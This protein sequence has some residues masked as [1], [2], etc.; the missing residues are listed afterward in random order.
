MIQLFLLMFACIMIVAWI[1]RPGSRKHYEECSQIP[2]HD[3]KDI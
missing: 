2:L 1:M 3:E